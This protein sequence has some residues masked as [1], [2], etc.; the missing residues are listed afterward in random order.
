MPKTSANAAKIYQ[1]LIDEKEK[2]NK[3]FEGTKC[4]QFLQ[5]LSQK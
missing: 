5:L 1:K 3:V 2:I 4:L